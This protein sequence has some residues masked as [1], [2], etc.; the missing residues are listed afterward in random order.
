MVGASK[1]NT[2]RA[3]LPDV[4]ERD[5]VRLFSLVRLLVGRGFPAL[6]F[7]LRPNLPFMANAIVFLIG[8]SGVF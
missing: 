7:M 1:L 3:F 4:R 2:T 8:G 6:V 5:P